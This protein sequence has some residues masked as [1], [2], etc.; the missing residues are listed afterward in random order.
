MINFSG[1]HRRSRPPSRTGSVIQ[2]N[3]PGFVNTRLVNYQRGI[4]HAPSMISQRPETIH[5]ENIPPPSS[6]EEKSK[7]TR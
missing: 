3:S 5:H 2:S 1:I 4:S 6:E 7:M